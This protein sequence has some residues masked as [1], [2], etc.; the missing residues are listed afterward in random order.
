LN[1]PALIVVGTCE[2]RPWG[3]PVQLRHR[4][5][6]ARAGVD[7]DQQAGHGGAVIAVRAE[8]VLDEALVRALAARPGVVLMAPGTA[9]GE[10]IAVAAHA[11]ADQAGAAL[12]LVRAGRVREGTAL[13]HGLTAVGPDEL[14]ST[15]NAALRK[16]EPPLLL[17]LHEIPRRE[18]ERR[19]FAAA[20][21][22]VTDLVT[23]WCWPWPALHATRWAARWGLSPNTVTSA[24]LALVILAT[25]LFA[26][27][28]LAA[29]IV[30]AWAMTFLDT[31]DGK[32]ARVTLSSSR[33]GN[34]YDHGI[35]LLHPPFWWWAWFNGLPASATLPAPVLE[36]ALWVI[37]AGYVLGRVLEGIFLHAFGIQTHVWRPVDA[38]FRTI[39]ARRNPNLLI[40][41][42]A[43]A[44]GRPDAG[45]VLV[46]V[47]TVISLVFHGVRLAQAAWQH[48]RGQPIRSWLSEPAP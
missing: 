44:A 10:R 35:D 9:P 8:Y 2:V 13:A 47:W 4:R 20:Y 21:K 6:F 15:Y 24:S 25:W 12:A 28:W 18:A 19:T 23:K 29:G 36:G 48:H 40:L 26:Q 3:M 42:V 1:E 30:V 22:G 31:V 7:A 46:A 34:L 11:G 17:S 14:G 45:F 38:W 43:A 41:T 33:W 37:L 5:A 32:L 39:T 16:R 27:G